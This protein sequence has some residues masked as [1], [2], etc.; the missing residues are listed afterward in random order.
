MRPILEMGADSMRVVS[1]VPA[2][3]PRI[4]FGIGLAAVRPLLARRRR[5]RGGG[6]DSSG[7]RS[8][9]CRE[10]KFLRRPTLRAGPAIDLDRSAGQRYHGRE[11]QIDMNPVEARQAALASNEF[12]P[13]EIAVPVPNWIYDAARRVL[14]SGTQHLVPPLKKKDVVFFTGTGIAAKFFYPLIEVPKGSP[15]PDDYFCQLDV[16]GVMLTLLADADYAASAG[17]IWTTD[18]AALTGHVLSQLGDWL[19]NDLAPALGGPWCEN[20]DRSPRGR[21]LK[22]QHHDYMTIFYKPDYAKMAKQIERAVV[23]N[24]GGNEWHAADRE[25]LPKD[26]ILGWYK[27]T[28]ESVGFMTRAMDFTGRRLSMNVPFVKHALDVQLGKAVRL[29]K[30]RSVNRKTKRGTEVGELIR[31]RSAS[32]FGAVALRE[33]VDLR[34]ALHLREKHPALDDLVND[35]LT[36]GDLSHDFTRFL[37]QLVDR[38]DRIQDAALRAA[39]VYAVGGLGAQGHPRWDRAA[40]AKQYRVT[41]RQ[42]EL[43]TEQAAQVLSEILAA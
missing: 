7:D 30:T 17:F 26:A 41:P 36:R 18:R 4:P 5:R 39:V 16:L 34:D 10:G 1:A 8:A 27:L 19:H 33:L 13:L 15:P 35:R 42:V 31:D 28:A 37:S 2:R 6:P 38:L 43:R 40:L 20:P 22:K 11:R 12:R 24:V 9:R 23:N 21:A 32:T 29:K 3:S 25:S 14:A